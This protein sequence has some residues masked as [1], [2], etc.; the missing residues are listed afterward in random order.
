MVLTSPLNC[1]VLRMWCGLEKVAGDSTTS[2]W[3]VS[4]CSKWVNTPL[5]WQMMTLESYTTNLI[6]INKKKKENVE[7]IC[8]SLISFGRQ[9]HRQIH[10][11]CSFKQTCEPSVK[12]SNRRIDSTWS[13]SAAKLQRKYQLV[14]LAAWRENIKIICCFWGNEI[15][16]AAGMA[17]LV[18]SG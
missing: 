17:G 10:K 7:R 4:R 6:F 11:R 12:K 16:K 5:S 13:V 9:T 15:M 8:F 14:F 1:R 18:K 3:V 2:E